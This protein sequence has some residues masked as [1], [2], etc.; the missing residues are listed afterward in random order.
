MIRR[1]PISTRTDTLFP[2]TTLFR[3]HG[4]HLHRIGARFQ[5]SQNTP[6]T[7]LPTQAGQRGG[8]GRWVMGEIVVDID[9][10][11]AAAQLHAPL[12]ALEGRQCLYAGLRADAQEIG[13][14]SGRERGGQYG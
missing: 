11:H 4:A 13:R 1:P 2:Y 8:D 12:D 10:A 9:A 5:Y 6:R 7:K 14:E 3:S